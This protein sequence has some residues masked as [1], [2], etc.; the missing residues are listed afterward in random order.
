MI[1]VNY[2][3]MMGEDDDGAVANV[4]VLDL[5]DGVVFTGAVVDANGGQWVAL[6]SGPASAVAT[7]FLDERDFRLLCQALRKAA[8]AHGWRVD[9]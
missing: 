9:L 7:P 4:T 8:A 5:R 6:R 2:L 1:R 3:Q